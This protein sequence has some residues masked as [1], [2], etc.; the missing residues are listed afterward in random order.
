LS[1]S[2]SIYYFTFTEAAILLSFLEISANDGLSVGSEAQQLSIRD[3][4]SG[5][6]HVGI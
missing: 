5:S 1:V 4:H 3:F 2:T 6:H